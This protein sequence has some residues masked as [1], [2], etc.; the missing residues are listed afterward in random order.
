MKELIDD[1]LEQAN[2]SIDK[3]TFAK[4]APEKPRQLAQYEKAQ[5]IILRTDNQLRKPQQQFMHL[6]DNSYNPFVPILTQKYFTSLSM[7]DEIVKLQNEYRANPE[8]YRKVSIKDAKK[9]QP[10]TPHPYEKELVDLK[11]TSAQLSSVISEQK[12]KDLTNTPFTFVQ[13]VQGLEELARKLRS[14]TECA[15]D[16]EHHSHRSYLGLTSLMQIS[17]RTEDFIIDVLA[18]RESMP[19]LAEVCRTSDNC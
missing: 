10:H 13:S 16:L 17:T 5:E 3:M 12:Y 9:S 6:I 11:Y 8:Q 1:L 18:L 4:A 2:A 14:V 15:V 7:P 19:M